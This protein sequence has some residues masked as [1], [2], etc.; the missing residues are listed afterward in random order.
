MAP[1]SAEPNYAPRERGTD[2]LYR[3]IEGHLEDFLSE[4]DAA[5]KIVPAFVRRAFWDYLDCGILERGFALLRCED[6]GRTRTVAQSCQNRGFCPS[7]LGRR[8]AQTAAHLVDE[9]LPAVPVRQWVLSLPI[10]LRFTL[11]RNPALRKTVLQIFL[12]VVFRWYENRAKAA[13]APAGQTGGVVVCQEFGS[14]LN[15]NLHF[16]AILFDG[17][18]TENATGGVDFHPSPSPTTAEVAEI[19]AQVHYRVDRMLLRRGLLVDEDPD[20]DT[21]DA[22]ATLQFASLAGRIALGKRAGKRPRSLVGPPGADR[23]LPNRCARSGWYNL[24]A[25]VRVAGGDAVARER[26]CRYILRPPLSHARLSERDDGTLVLRLKTAWRN[27]TTALILSPTELLQ[28]LAA[29]IPRPRTHQITY[30]GVLGG[31]ARLRSKVVPTP[32][33]R[34][35]E[36]AWLRTAR[37]KAQADPPRWKVRWIPWAQLL[38]REFGVEG[39]RCE[40]GGW[41]RVHAIVMGTP[42]TQRALKTLQPSLLRSRGPPDEQQAA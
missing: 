5:D 21:D 2:L 15:L 28:R 26:L 29:I 11:A 32:P 39:M 20:L 18:F 36:R 27:G 6:C 16:H 7:C 19:V 37:S 22:A 42:A 3:V 14:A 30:H 17:A 34:Q 24:H 38:F 12:R 10:P 33:D 41:M 25:G 13:G 23:P 35:L 31:N 4:A 9:V 1:A 40:C 8:M